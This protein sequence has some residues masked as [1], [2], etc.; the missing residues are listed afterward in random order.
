MTKKL[1]STTDNFHRSYS[2]EILPALAVRPGEEFTLETRSILGPGQNFLPKSYEDLVIPVTGPVAIKGVHAGDT[3]RVDV[4]GIEIANRGAMVTLTD[5]GAF[6]GV[7]PGGRVIQIRKGSAEFAPGFKVPVRPM[8]GKIGVAVPGAAPVSSTVG[9]FGGN[10]DNKLLREGC[11]IFLV[12]QVDE[13]LIYAGDLHACQAD[14]ESALTALEV[15]GAITLRVS[16]VPK[17]PT[18]LPVVVTPKTTLVIGSGMSLEEAISEALLGMAAFLCQKH[19]W[20]LET[21]AMALSLT[22]EV[23]VCQLVN[24]RVSAKVTINNSYLRGLG[25]GP[26]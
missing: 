17:L 10:M 3:L 15:A 5:Y 2:S 4:L 16:V 8:V 9:D 7:G 6:P 14:G 13:G 18:H 20:P 11:S 1:V 21:A 19:S 25:I 23:G 24:P 22:G 26:A 12:A